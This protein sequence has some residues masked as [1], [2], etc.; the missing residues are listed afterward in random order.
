MPQLNPEFFI[1]QLFWLFVSFSF[2]LF[3]LWKISLPRISTVMLARENKINNEIQEAKKLQAEA[4]NIQKQ[5][6]FQ[7][8][9]AQEQSAK[10]IKETITNMQ[11]K[12]SSELTKID[13][14]L[15]KK[16]E[17]STIA[18][19]KN[20]DNLV[21]EINDQIKEITQLTLQK[22]LTLNVEDNEIKNVISKIQNNKIN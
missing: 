1:S 18:I 5:I 22:L 2:L 8:R 16:I 17:E 19:Q 3:F 4:E 11:D 21:L 10:T 6:E 9:E 7:L 20:K 12:T 14:D 13:N 15:T